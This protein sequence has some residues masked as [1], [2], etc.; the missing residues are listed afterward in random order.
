MYQLIGGGS[1]A[2]E[3]PIKLYE[4]NNNP[5][6][7]KIINFIRENWMQY[8]DEDGRLFFDNHP[9]IFQHPRNIIHINDTYYC[10]AL[11]C[12]DLMGDGQNLYSFDAASETYYL[13][14]DRRSYD[15]LQWELYHNGELFIEWD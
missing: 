11:N 12:S 4:G 1:N 14:D 2:I 9:D 8:A 13:A 15:I 10:N 3:L 5:E 6:A 7:I